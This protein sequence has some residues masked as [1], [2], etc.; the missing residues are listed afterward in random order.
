[1]AKSKKVTAEFDTVSE[2]PNKYTVDKLNESFEKIER[3]LKEELTGKDYRTQIIDHYEKVNNVQSIKT[4]PKKLY[5]KIRIFTP[6]DEAQRLIMEE[7]MNNPKF[8]V[9]SIKETWTVK[10]VYKVAVWY[11]ENLDYKP[12]PTEK[13]IAEGKE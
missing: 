7:L 10:G 6:E 11:T 9:T 4:K 2:L 5:N 12:N 1:M 13:D 3:N 8:R